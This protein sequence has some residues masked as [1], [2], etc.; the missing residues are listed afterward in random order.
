MA[1][2][3]F[4][5]REF[6][7]FAEL[8]VLKR[9][10]R[11]QYRI[12]ACL[13]A[14]AVSLR[15]KDEAPLNQMFPGTKHLEVRFGNSDPVNTPDHFHSLDLRHLQGY[16]TLRIT[17]IAAGLP[18]VKKTLRISVPGLSSEG[19]GPARPLRHENFPSAGRTYQTAIYHSHHNELRGSVR[20]ESDTNFTMISL[21]KVHEFGYFGEPGVPK[22]AS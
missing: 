2:E 21:T 8:A 11:H 22:F 9:N 4:K 6:C 13:E 3:H 10:V 16:P 12:K 20:E 5:D 1:V 7:R 17:T 15:R 18:F 14:R 19:A